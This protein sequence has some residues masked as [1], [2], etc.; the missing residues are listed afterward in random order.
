MEIWFTD[1]VLGR[2]IFNN[3]ANSY[4]KEYGTYPTVLDE[5]PGFLYKQGYQFSLLYT[6]GRSG[7]SIEGEDAS[8]LI[9]KY[10]KIRNEI[11]E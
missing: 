11:L 4:K 8:A 1:N 9:L 2:N 3:V 6:D 10:G 7:L 5:L